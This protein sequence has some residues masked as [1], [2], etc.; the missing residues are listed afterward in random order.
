MSGGSMGPGS[1]RRKCNMSTNT[2]TPARTTLKL[3]VHTPAERVA[4]PGRVRSTLSPTRWA[5][6]SDLNQLGASRKVLCEEI[7]LA[8][9]EYAEALRTLPQIERRAVRHLRQA[10]REKPKK[11]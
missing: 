9:A 2:R 5:F 3:A 1:S 6:L 7:M 10:L 11:G 4:K 8:D